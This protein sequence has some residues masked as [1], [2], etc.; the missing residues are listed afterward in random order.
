MLLAVGIHGVWRFAWLLELCLT[1]AGLSFFYFLCRKTVKMG[2]G[3]TLRKTLRLGANFEKSLLP[4]MNLLFLI[5]GGYYIVYFVSK[6]F[7]YTDLAKGLKPFRDSFV[8][9]SIA[10]MALRWKKEALSLKFS[11][12]L[13]MLSA[14]NKITSISILLLSGLVILRIFSLDVMPLIAFGGIGA[15]ALGFASK[16][17]MSS[18]LGGVQLAATRVFSIGDLIA[19]PD[20][21][22]EGV[23]EEI[24][25]SLTLVRDL[26]RRLVYLPNSIFSGHLVVN[27]SRRTERR[28]RE[29]IGLRYQD[30]SKIPAIVKEIK[31][32]M[33]SSSFLDLRRVPL[34]FIGNMGEYSIGLSIDI[35]TG[36]T[37]W[38]DY[39]LIKEALLKTVFTVAKKHGAEIAYPIS[40]MEDPFSG[41]RS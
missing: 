8:V 30:F 11:R 9:G 26:E 36:P 3:K 28:T 13:T 20:K 32:E 37:L 18:F 35:H 17:V 2:G 7:G 24:G 1:I 25:W 41:G 33:Q 5:L 4:S 40:L 21:D 22:L 12:D 34:V 15:A 10:W 23:V 39:V 31:E 19:I 6:H 27:A 38:K 16:D 14:L 29:T